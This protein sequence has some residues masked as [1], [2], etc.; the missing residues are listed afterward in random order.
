MK[1]A[2]GLLTADRHDLTH[3]TVVSF[4]NHVYR[5]RLTLL[6]ADDGS[7]TSDNIDIARAAGFRT[8]YMSCERRGQVPA[9]DALVRHA[10]ASGATHFMY[11]ENDWE[12]VRPV[13]LA[14]IAYLAGNFTSVRFYGA[15]K[16]STEPK[17]KTGEHIIGTKTKIDW[18]PLTWAPGWEGTMAAHW[19][20]PPSVTKIQPLAEALKTAK[21]IGDLN[22]SLARIPSARPIE[23]FVEHIGLERTPGFKV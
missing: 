1:L 18:L 16:R 2:V 9:I 5:G 21:K 22:Y 13:P 8:V 15:W 10:L 4:I 7:E 6:H 12:F 11:L 3:R 14:G 20:G 19:G 23:N 17:Q